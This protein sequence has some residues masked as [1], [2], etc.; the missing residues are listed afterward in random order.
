MTTTLKNS[1]RLTKKIDDQT[2]FIL[3]FL[4]DFLDKLFA[5]KLSFELKYIRLLRLT[6]EIMQENNFLKTVYIFNAQNRFALMLNQCNFTVDFLRE[7]SGFEEQ[8]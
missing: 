6:C 1:Y 2:N 8:A 7:M 3:L 4:F 5:I